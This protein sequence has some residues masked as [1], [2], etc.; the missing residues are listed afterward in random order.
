MAKFYGNFFDAIQSFV[1]ALQTHGQEEAMG[2]LRFCG[3]SEDVVQWIASSVKNGEGRVIERLIIQFS[4]PPGFVPP[5]PLEVI[6]L[7]DPE[8]DP[9]EDAMREH[10]R[11]ESHDEDEDI[12]TEE[13]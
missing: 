13:D 7:D 12:D 1:G 9:A 6:H 10:R 5:P 11:L 3:L 2:R 4:P 8:D